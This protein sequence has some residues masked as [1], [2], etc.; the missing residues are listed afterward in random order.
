MSK[1]LNV[2]KAGVSLVSC[3][4]EIAGYSSSIKYKYRASRRSIR[5]W[6]PYHQQPDTYRPS[7][8]KMQLPLKSISLLPA[9]GSAN[10]IC[11]PAGPILPRPSI[12]SLSSSSILQDAAA[13]LT[14]TLDAALKGTI[15]TG[16]ETANVSL[17]LAIV[18]A[19]Q[20]DPR[21]PIWEYHHRAATNERGV[22]KIDKDSQYLIGSISKLVSDYVMLQT[23]VDIDT[24]V[25]KFLPKLAETP[26]KIRWEE[27]T[28]RM[29]ASHLAGIPANCEFSIELPM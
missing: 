3:R 1:S 27:I 15:K 14:S 9:L 24:P 19:N 12:S 6:F 8:D 26:S 5:V 13:N 20:T 7:T 22:S 16:W 28:L 25:T 29:L 4:H 17:S 23:G 10:L 21:T 18:S 11:G 2:K